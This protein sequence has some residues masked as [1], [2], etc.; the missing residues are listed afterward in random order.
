MTSEG[1]KP[2]TDTPTGGQ[3]PIMEVEWTMEDWTHQER[4]YDENTPQARTSLT[5]RFKFKDLNVLKAKEPYPFPIAEIAVPYTD[6]GR[7]SG[8]TRW[9]AVSA[10]GRKIFGGAF[11]LDALKGK[12]QKWAQLPF[13]LRQSLKNEDGTD[14]IDERGRAVWGDVETDCWQIVSVEGIGTGGPSQA[15]DIWAYMAGLAEGCDETLFQSK[16]IADQKITSNQEIVTH[17]TDRTLVPNMLSLG[18]I[19][20]DEQGVLHATVAS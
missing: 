7:S 14:Q 19:S 11:D 3:S 9:E 15:E 1:F 16:L 6:P 8:G 17:I 18:K 20:R 4:T 10:S 2:R 12:R 5:L 13:K